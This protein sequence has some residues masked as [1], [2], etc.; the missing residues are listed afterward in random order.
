MNS[1]PVYKLIKVLSQELLL[2]HPGH[3]QLPAA[4]EKNNLCK[5]P[6]AWPTSWH[7]G[8]K[9][10]VRPGLHCPSFAGHLINM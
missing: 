4:E 2:R 10:V 8:S 3:G 9:F 7:K 6:E 5:R 1:G